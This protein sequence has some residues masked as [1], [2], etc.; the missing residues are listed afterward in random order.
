MVTEK[1]TA[2]PEGVIVKD[3]I[4]LQ[5]DASLIPADG[6]VVLPEGIVGIAGE[7]FYQTPIQK[8]NIPYHLKVYWKRCVCLLQWLERGN[9][10]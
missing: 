5:W 3:H 10:S 8:N 1:P 6:K 9:S 2:I 7:A 4:V